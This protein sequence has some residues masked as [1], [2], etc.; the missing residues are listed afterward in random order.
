M[1]TKKLES[2]PAAKPAAEEHLVTVMVPYI[3]GEDPE[4]TV[5]LN[6]NEVTKFRRGELV[7][8]KPAVAQIVM[9][10]MKQAVVVEQNKKKYKMQ[11]MEL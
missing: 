2:E 6:C 8:V 11:V 10:S 3:E 9:N 1:A 5:V 7:Q 4:V